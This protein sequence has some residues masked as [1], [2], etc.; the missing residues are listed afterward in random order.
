MALQ[1]RSDPE[2]S[3]VSTINKPAP[4]SG[5]FFPHATG[6]AINGGDSPGGHKS[7]ERKRSSESGTVGRRS[8]VAGVRR[9]YCAKVEGRDSGRMTVA[10]YQGDGSEELYGLISSGGLRAL[11]FHDELIPYNQFLNRYR[12]SPILTT[13]ILGYCTTEWEAANEYLGSVSLIDDSDNTVWI[14]PATGQLCLDLAPNSEMES[15]F[16]PVDTRDLNHYV[17][18]LEDTWTD[19]INSVVAIRWDSAKALLLLRNYRYL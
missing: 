13:Y 14:R 12:N 17:P 1:P 19:I 18:R 6:F 5:A 8:R 16:E 11:V 3:V 2:L 15:E 10:M 7:I 9:M 4:Y